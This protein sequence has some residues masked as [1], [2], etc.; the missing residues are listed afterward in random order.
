MTRPNLAVSL[1]VILAVLCVAP[2][3]LAQQKAVSPATL[4]Y[5]FFKA[6]V[7]PIFLAKRPGHA[8]CIA[9]HGEG[10]TMRMEPVSEGRSTWTEE[11]ARKNFEI[12]RLRVVPNDPGRS[13][14]LIHP[15]ALEAGGDL[16]HSGGK[17]WKS[18]DDP[19]WQTLANWVCGRKTNEKLLELTGA[20]CAEWEWTPKCLERP[21]LNAMTDRIANCI[22]FAEDAC[23]CI[24]RPAADNEDGGNQNENRR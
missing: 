15:L 2:A 9:C 13:R 4:D 22:R 20:A 11:Q 21:F 12:V 14:V 10:T 16:Y 19:E 3:L 7:Q 23:L 8:R 6:N 5:E 1:A 17:H 24:Q 18:Q